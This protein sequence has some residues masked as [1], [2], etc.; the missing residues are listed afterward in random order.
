MAWFGRIRRSLAVLFRRD[1]LDRDLEEEMQSHLE[2]QERENQE[3]GMPARDAAFAA[4]R[5]F[6]N[7]A[8]LGEDS[9]E[10][11]GWGPLE[12]LWQD[13]AY[14]VRVL[15]KNP[16]FTA[17]ALAVLALGSG[18]NTAIFTEVNATLLRPLPFRNAQQ[19]VYFSEVNRQKGL[20]GGWVAPG[21][22][23]EWRDR[24]RLMQNMGAFTSTQPIL[25]GA[26]EP[27]RVRGVEATRSL[28]ETLAIAPIL[29][30]TFA[31]EEEQRGKNMVALLGERLWRSRFGGRADVLGRTAIFDSKPYTVV[32]VVS[33]DVPIDGDPWDVWFPLALGPGAR[34]AHNSFYLFAI[35]RMKPGVTVEQARRDMRAI[36]D[37]IYR[38]NSAQGVAGWEVV[39]ESLR[40]RLA[41]DRRQQ[42]LLLSAAV[43]LLLLI[44]CVNVATLFL[45]RSARRSREMAVRAALGAGRWRIV[46][47]LLTESMI[48][49][50]AAGGVG[51]LLARW[52]TQLLYRWMAPMPGGAPPEVD[53]T[54]LAFTLAV[55]A[56]VGML[57]GVAP[58]LRAS[59][60]DLTGTLRETGRGAALGRGRLAG[61][62]VVAEAALAVVLLIGAGLLIRSFARL[63]AVDPG[64][65]PEHLLTFHVP[66]TGGK[67]QGSRRVA[68]YEELLDRLRALP[69]VRAAGGADYLP[70][71]GAG[72]SI[73]F[74][75][76]GR[77][78]N[79]AGAF[80]GQRIVTPGYFDA[81]G[82][83]LAGGRGLEAHD[84]S[85]KPEVAVVNDAMSTACWPGEDAIGKRF[86]LN[87]RGNSSWITVVGVVHDVKHFGLDGKKWPEAFFPER[88][89]TWASLRVVVRTVA[90][91]QA[92]LPAARDVI[93]GMDP[94]VPV[95]EA[96]SMEKIVAGSVAPRQLSMILVAA[97]AGLALALASIG[98]YGVIASVVA[99]RRHELGIRMALGA[100]RRDLLRMVIGRGMTLAAAGLAAGA[101]AS[102]AL[103]RLL[104]GMLFGITALDPLTYAAVAVAVLTT[105]FAATYLPARAAAHSDPIEA[106]RHE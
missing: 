74:A 30:R 19:L 91:P 38:E 25:T 24:S 95:A 34:R 105:A 101:A 100:E 14:A 87:P 21:N 75:V 6:G 33:C 18:A 86:R 52:A 27:E 67:Y 10:A 57:F 76:E 103:T 98:L 51:L 40:N 106:L 53:L 48:L 56:G 13:I 92:L 31:A 62:L 73:E 79:G 16:G 61:A 77:P 78:W 36:G 60:L 23:L 15:R 12:R 39:T 4:R 50:L 47:Q 43:G 1:R 54:V 8:L 97:F 20:A 28:L 29:G 44:A 94:A 65:R 58:A 102:L 80:V 63:V 22:Y 59:R 64:F 93:R 84:D 70:I 2:F 5:Q 42:L 88:Q 104:S 96:R 9:R 66:L 81:M 90:D 37:R 11:W 45:T 85:T 68:F 83:S 71:E 72:P 3:R 46:R 17:I 41:G 7:V 69:G 32:G 26:G 49:S 55:S 82:M 89:R 99:Q 35:G